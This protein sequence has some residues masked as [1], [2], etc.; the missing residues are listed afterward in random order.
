MNT[1]LVK[2]VLIGGIGFVV[3]GL[4][5]AF[6][7]SMLSGFESTRNDTESYTQVDT[8]KV[9]GAS[10]SA[11]HTTITLARPM[12]AADTNY[13]T[14]VT[15]NQSGDSLSVV[16]ATLTTT[17]TNI[18]GFVSTNG[19]RTVTTTYDYG[20]G[21]YY[22]GLGTVIQMGP[23]IVLL[24]FII[25]IGVVAYMGIRLNLGKGR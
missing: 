7:P 20:T 9:I 11:N 5:L 12:L 23:S 17:S 22:T 8:G 13:I 24:G 2:R 15:S 19:T 3:I 18:T 25:L 4:A 10:N 21:Q 16:A 6:G 1:S 14:S